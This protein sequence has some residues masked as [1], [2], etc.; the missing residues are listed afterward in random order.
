MTK[1]VFF[2]LSR[3]R[4]KVRANCSLGVEQTEFAIRLAWDKQVWQ[5]A[6]SQL[7]LQR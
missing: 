5:Q 1:R 7:L 3:V 6:G 4:G 2:P